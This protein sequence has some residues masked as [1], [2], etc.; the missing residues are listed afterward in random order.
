M[1]T[2]DDLMMIEFSPDETS[3][4][5]QQRS[6]HYSVA[7][8]CLREKPESVKFMVIVTDPRN[9]STRVVIE[10]SR[11]ITE[12]SPWTYWAHAPLEL[13][14]LQPMKPPVLPTSR[15]DKKRMIVET[16]ETGKDEVPGNAHD[17]Q[18]EA[19]AIGKKQ[20][21]RSGQ[22]QSRQDE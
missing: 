6:K 10:V 4:T 21:Q 22:F 18:A 2:K 20:K 16:V 8:L 11:D 15:R 13:V 5:I 1:I 12:A 17:D 9:L 19:D 7:R 14:P 3:W